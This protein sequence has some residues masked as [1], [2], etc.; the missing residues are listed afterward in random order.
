M[1][2]YAIPGFAFLLLII[3]I[4]HVPLLKVLEMSKANSALGAF[5]A[6]LSLFTGS[7]IGFLISQFWWLWFSHTDRIFGIKGFK[8]LK[9]FLKQ[10]CEKYGFMEKKEKEAPWNTILDYIRH[11]KSKGEIAKLAK[12][13]WDMYHVLMSTFCA[14]V[15]GLLVGIGLRIYFEWFIFDPLFKIPLE[16]YALTPLSENAEAVALLTIYVCV[17]FLLVVFRIGSLSLMTNYRPLLEAL[18]RLELGEVGREELAK[19]FPDYFY[20]HENSVN[21]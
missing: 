3:L 17:M 12:R 4:N 8:S 21:S 18:I 2:R 16:A 14:L 20:T 19:V 11:R 9:G 15:I 13:R 10:E 6:F 1:H 5:L 7:A